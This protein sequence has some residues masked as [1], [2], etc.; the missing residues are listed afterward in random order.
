LDTG[1]Y[2]KLLEYDQL[3]LD[4]GNFEYLIGIDICSY[5]MPCKTIIGDRSI[6]ITKKRYKS[7]V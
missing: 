2:E 4:R 3:D 5:R 6:D 7:K 1:N